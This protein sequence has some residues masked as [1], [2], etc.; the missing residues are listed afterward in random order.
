MSPLDS[1]STLTAFSLVSPLPPHLVLLQAGLHKA[2]IM[3]MFKTPQCTHVHSSA[4]YKS[5]EVKATH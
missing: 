4:I 3:I 1:R 5:Q 2:F